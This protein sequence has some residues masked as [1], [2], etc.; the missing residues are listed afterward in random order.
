MNETGNIFYDE[1][2]GKLQI[3]EDTLSYIKNG[4]YHIDDINDIF[5]AIHTIKGTADLLGMTEVVNLTH[6]AEDLLSEVRED[7][8]KFT[9]NI[10]HLFMEL[11]KLLVKMVD[12]ILNGVDIDL[13]TKKLILACETDMLKYINHNNEDKT[14]PKT[15]LV[16][17]DS[18]LVREQIKFIANDAGFVVLLAD[19]KDLA[20][21]KL[22][23][24]RVDIIF[25]DV[26]TPMFDGID[27]IKSL[28]EI[29]K[30]LNIPIVLLV[31]EQTQE[32]LKIAKKYNATAWLQKPFNNNKI[33]IILKKIFQK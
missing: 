7:R 9:K 27:L 21:E 30:F 2:M 23:E 28:K 5:R 6:R 17:D 25:C 22:D 4:D 11:K 14:I 8:L 13:D 26:A 1:M 31:T 29:D 15:I 10:Y 24:H 18:S 32:M 19:S 12:S 3:M 33:E 20:L 16:V